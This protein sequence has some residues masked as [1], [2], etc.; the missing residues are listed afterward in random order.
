MPSVSP[1]RAHAWT[2]FFPATHDND[3]D[4]NQ[5]P[6]LSLLYLQHRKSWGFVSAF[7]LSGGLHALCSLFTHDHPVVRLKAITT[8]VSITA[9]EDFDWFRP[10]IRRRRGPAGGAGGGA[11]GDNTTE[12]KLHRALLSLRLDP[13][14]I[15]GLIANSW[16]RGSIAAGAEDEGR[17]QTF[18][19]GCLMCLEVR[20]PSF[21]FPEPR[22]SKNLVKRIKR[23][24]SAGKQNQ[25]IVNVR[26]G[27]S[28]SNTCTP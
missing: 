4:K 24:G 2:V 26:F 20:Y 5:I 21:M 28:W 11:G 23:S 14:F 6:H 12:A 17:G 15:S 3:D 8:F 27:C 13:S 19:G 25:S 1:S 16:G 18:P 10:V 7:I 22:N 9:H